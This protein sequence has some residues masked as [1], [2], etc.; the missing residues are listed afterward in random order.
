[1]NPLMTLRWFDEE[2]GTVGEDPW[3]ALQPETAHVLWTEPNDNGLHVSLVLY[4][5]YFI[6]QHKEPFTDGGNIDMF[7]F[8][9]N[10]VN[11]IEL[12]RPDAGTLA[13]A[14]VTALIANSD[15]LI[16]SFIEQRMAR[17]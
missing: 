10:V 12:G 13:V 5:T 8:G 2:D 3:P 6:V 11:Y 15:Q 17:R 1:M 4:G 7:K 16:K 14:L 9:G